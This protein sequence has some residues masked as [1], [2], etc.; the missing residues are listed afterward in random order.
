[1]KLALLGADADSLALAAAAIAVG[2]EISWQGDLAG[3]DR[4]RFSWLTAEDRGE[5]WEDLHDP[6]RA[7]AVIVGR[8]SAGQD[9][10]A[11]QVQEL[12]KLGRPL[13]SVHPLFDS[14]LTYFEVDLARGESHAVVEHFN[15]LVESPMAAA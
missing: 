11:R 7:D 1:M 8:G 5:Q 3:A 14:V 9:L 2:H 15:P 4:S 13:L 6:G 12:V 10:R